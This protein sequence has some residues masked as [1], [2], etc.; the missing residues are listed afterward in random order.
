MARR[1]HIEFDDA[2]VVNF[3]WASRSITD[4][5]HEQE[6]LNAERAAAQ[7]RW[8]FEVGHRIMLIQALNV[9][10]SSAA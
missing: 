5:V 9:I 7:A 6:R 2:F 1:C 10:S 3:Q 8:R 4:I